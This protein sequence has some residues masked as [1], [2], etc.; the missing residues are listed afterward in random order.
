MDTKSFGEQAGREFMAYTPY[1]DLN[2]FFNF[3]DK[4]KGGIVTKEQ[5]N[6][7][8]YTKQN[9]RHRAIFKA[10]D[11]LTSKR[12]RSCCVE[13]SYVRNVY[14]YFTSSD[15]ISQN[16]A[17]AEKINVSYITDWEK[18]HDSY[19]GT[20]K[21]E[22]LVVCYLSGPE[23]NNDFQELINLGILPHNIWAFESD[24]QVYKK[25]IAAYNQGEYPQPRIL[26]QNIETFF[27]QTPKKFD[28]IYI[29]A[30]G[31]IP[32]TQHALRSVFSVC[33]N[34]RL[35]SPGVIITNFA[36]PDIAN[37][38]IGDYYELISQYLF[39]KKYPFAEFEISESRIKNKEYDNILNNVTEK[40]DLYYGEFI[41]AVLRDIPAV[42]VPVQRIAQ[43]PYL[44]QLFDMIDINRVNE[45]FIN[46]SKGN[47]LARYFFTVNS[48][49]E[50]GLL[51]EKSRCFLNEIGNFHDLIKGLKLTVLL[52]KGKLR[53]KEDVQKI[54]EYFENNNSLYQFCDKPHSNLFFDIILNQL[55]YPMHNNILQNA[56]YQYVAKSNHMFTDITVYDECR[57]IYEW[58]PG[59]HQIVSSFENNS[60]QYIFRFALDGLVKMR[61]NYNNEF[62][63]QGSIVSNVVEGFSS[64]K[65]VERI[66]IN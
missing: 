42:I 43:N 23:P 29:D 57:Y 10:V 26:K 27:Q 45:D 49:L 51:D 65:L 6:Y 52:R 48:L 14:D 59:L 9:V 32:S 13:R 30:C 39:F 40:F 15:D 25:A 46:I 17:E 8:Q 62:F 58:L 50:T 66:V 11:S 7:N 35:N 22:D 36:M 4:K 21:P 3:M 34:H 16:G 64:K 37:E 63:F 47:S 31:S 33:Q 18:L 2:N 20:K 41:S 12:E 28:I 54:K 55:A 38:A 56:R 19:V 44:Y 5:Y 60:W 24:N 61:Q 53:L 1:N